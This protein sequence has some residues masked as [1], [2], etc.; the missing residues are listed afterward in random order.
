MHRHF[1]HD[2]G[3]WMYGWYAWSLFVPI[4]L[5]AGTLIALVQS[6]ALGRRI[7]RSAAR[8]LLKIGGMPI[9]AQGLSNL[10]DHPHVLLINHTSFLDA[11]VLTAL[12]P[13]NP[14]YAF[15]VRQQFASQ[16]LLWPLLRGVGTLVLQPRH[17]KHVT[18]NVELLTAALR[19]GENLAVFPEGR[20]SAEPGLKAFHSGAFVAAENA[21]VP[22]VVAGLRGARAALPL[23]TWLPRRT[24]IVLEIG[25]MFIPDPAEWSS[26]GR[27]CAAARK[28]MVA[29]S[30][31]PDSLRDGHPGES[32]A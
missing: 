27:L 31:E 30:G 3:T 26:T 22:I 6:S 17:Q 20:F 8:L 24:A 11:I 32:H 19:R 18:S 25:P 14:G 9:S 13:A 7:A 16:I 1:F 29:L 2:L 15:A 23:G 4:L 28:A 12:L 10:P 21:R 5:L